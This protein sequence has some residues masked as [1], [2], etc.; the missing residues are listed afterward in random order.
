M[1]NKITK[2]EV[3]L[4]NMHWT[5]IYI[6]PLLLGVAFLS[7]CRKNPPVDDAGDLSKIAYQPVSYE[8]EI[9]EIYK[10]LG[11]EIPIDNPITVEGLDLGHKLFFD[12]ILSVDSTVSCA[13]CHLPRGA[14]TDNLP[15]SFGV[16]NKLG[17]RSAMSLLNVGFFKNGLF[18]DGRAENLEA[19]ALIP[20][21]DPVEMA[22]SLVGVETALR[23]HKEYPA[24][25]R[26][27]FGIDHI[28]QI[29][30]SLV[31]KALAQYQRT[32][33]SGGQAKFDRFLRN[34]YLFTDEEQNG[35]DMFF[36]ANPDIPDA[37]C[38]HCHPSPLFTSNQYINNGLDTV[39][40]L[41]DFE[42]Q[43]RGAVSNKRIDNGRFR[44][45]T[46]RNIEFSAPYMHDG[47]FATLD[48]VLD[49]YNHGGFPAD[50]IDA[51]M[52]AIQL[53]EEEKQ[54]LISFLKTLT[55]TSYYQNPLFFS[56]F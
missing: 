26:R 11:L 42:D 27:A 53:S 41:E 51:N 22:H 3:I 9:P 55:D 50:N 47:R 31:A 32:L 46:L 4:Y 17:R 16:E 54:D 10:S 25:F 7:S 19:Q 52:R 45:P 30:A 43:G 20:I 23:T 34:E 33:I 28:D 56:P 12:P 38:A 29:N 39:S 24:A 5:Q 14:L 48:E 21:Q 36:D 1:Y 37:E 2:R 13:S 18:W 35:F 6:L 15:Q 40:S 44:V 49:H 8:V